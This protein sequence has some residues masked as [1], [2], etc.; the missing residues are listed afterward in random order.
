[1]PDRKDR[2]LMVNVLGLDA[3]MFAGNVRET[4][5]ENLRANHRTIVRAIDKVLDNRKENGTL[6]NDERR[7]VDAALETCEFVAAEI[8]LRRERGDAEPRIADRTASAGMFVETRTG[9]RIKLYRNNEQLAAAHPRADY[10]LGDAVRG[11][12]TGKWGE[13][14]DLAGASTTGGGVLLSPSVSARVVDLARAKSACV[15]AGA[16]TLPMDTGDVTIAKVSADPTAVWR[17]ENQAITASDLTFA[18]TTLKARTLGVLCKMSLELVEDAANLSSVVE[19]VFAGAIAAELDRVAL[20]GTGSAEEP[21]GLENTPSIGTATSVG[22]PTWDDF[23]DAQSTIRLANGEPNAAILSPR[24]LGTLGKLKGTANDHYIAPPSAL[25]S[26]SFLHTTNVPR[27]RGGGSNESLAF[28]GDYSNLWFGV[29]TSLKIEASRAA[30]DSTNSAFTNVQ[31]W[32]RG[33]IRVDVAV[34]RPSHFVVLSGI[35]A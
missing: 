30:A 14:R 32:M 15:R 4:P 27:N 11:I 28:V 2:D 34:V 26:I 8:Q 24:D 33:Y 17:A 3:A 6:T 13:A 31:L 5:T 10:G 29:R 19:G 20:V 12:V 25:S 23:V 22:S 16:L 9:E 18:G 1:M 35:T 7:A 21:M